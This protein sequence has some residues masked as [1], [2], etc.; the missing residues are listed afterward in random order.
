MARIRSIKPEVM[1]D[2]K[3]A[4]LSDAAW[5]LWVCMWVLADDS[6]RLPADPEWLNGQVFWASPRQIVALLG[7][8]TNG[9]QILLYE[10]NGEP[11]A[12]VKNFNKHQ[13]IDKPSKSKYPSPPDSPESPSGV[14]AEPSTSPSG[15][16]GKGREGKGSEGEGSPAWGP[17]AFSQLWT[18]TLGKWSS[19]DIGLLT[20]MADRC[21]A[22][23]VV[24]GQDVG[25]RAGALMLALALWIENWDIPSAAPQVKVESL[26]KHFSRCEDIADGKYVPKKKSDGGKGDAARLAA[27]I[28]AKAGDA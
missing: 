8:L 1:S 7:E 22:S 16:I 13:K 17:R 21:A 15:G 2:P 27:S 28:A 23:A 4:R 25:A 26:D 3:A 12:L 19:N 6:G 20:S 9:G 14:F 10:M 24:A 5:R 18:A 11:L